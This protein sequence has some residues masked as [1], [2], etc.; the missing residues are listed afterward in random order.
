MFK[1]IKIAIEEKTKPRI[2]VDKETPVNIVASCR[3]SPVELLA[4]DRILLKLEEEKTAIIFNQIKTDISS[5]FIVESVVSNRKGKINTILIAEIILIPL[6]NYLGIRHD[7]CI[8]HF[9]RDKEFMLRTM[10]GQMNRYFRINKN[11]IHPFPCTD[12]NKGWSMEI[13]DHGYWSTH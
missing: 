9:K 4:D 10:M 13:T 5:E 6:A 8:I 12:L 3:F 11:G 2:F 1:M 7:E